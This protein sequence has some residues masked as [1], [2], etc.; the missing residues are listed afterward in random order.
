MNTL[1]REGFVADDS[2]KPRIWRRAAKPRKHT[3]DQEKKDDKPLCQQVIDTLKNDGEL[4]K[5]DLPIDKYYLVAVISQLR[6][7]GHDIKAL[8]NDGRLMGYKLSA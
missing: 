5:D 8:T 3:P 7:K 2:I 4:Y 6:K 1:E